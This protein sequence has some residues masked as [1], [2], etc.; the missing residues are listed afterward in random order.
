[1]PKHVEDL[2]VSHKLFELVK[3]LKLPKTVP[4]KEVSIRSASGSHTFP[5]ERLH[6]AW[7]YGLIVNSADEQSALNWLDSVCLWVKGEI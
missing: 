7:R 3:L 2:M 1:M 4:V 5:M 6:E